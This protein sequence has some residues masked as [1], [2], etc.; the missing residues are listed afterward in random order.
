MFEVITTFLV[1]F[2]ELLPYLIVF[3][4]VM[5]LICSILFDRR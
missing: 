1:Q 2:C 3:L 5:N 4:L